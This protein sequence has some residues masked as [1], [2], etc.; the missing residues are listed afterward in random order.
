MIHPLTQTLIDGYLLFLIPCFYVHPAVNT[1]PLYGCY[2]CRISFW[3]MNRSVKGYT[4][5]EG[6]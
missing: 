3:E 1:L 2:E 4:Q 5:F 6:W